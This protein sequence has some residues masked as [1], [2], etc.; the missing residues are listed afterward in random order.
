MNIH[1]YANVLFA[2]LNTKLKDNVYA[3]ICDLV[4]TLLIYVEHR[5]RHKQFTMCTVK[6]Q[7]VQWGAIETVRIR[8]AQMSSF[9][10]KTLLI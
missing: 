4:P 9:F 6:I 7:F 2:Y 5:L 1:E 3:L 8:T 10:L